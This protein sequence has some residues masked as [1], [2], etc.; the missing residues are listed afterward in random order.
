M[1]EDLGSLT[2]TFGDVVDNND[3][4]VTVFDVIGTGVITGLWADNQTATHNSEF[5]LTIDGA[6]K[7]E[8]EA[9]QVSEGMN[10]IFALIYFATS[11]KLEMRQQPGGAS[12]AIYY[13]VVG[14]K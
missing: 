14:V 11:A 5:K 3:T 2:W 9:L 6:V 4:Y 7:Y 8:D 10:G 13:G 12:T 1:L